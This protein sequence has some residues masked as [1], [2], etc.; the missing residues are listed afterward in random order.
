MGASVADPGVLIV[1]VAV[2]GDDGQVGE[3]AERA[4]QF[5]G[6]ARAWPVNRDFRLSSAQAADVLFEP[7]QERAGV[8][9]T[10]GPG[11]L[12]DGNMLR[13]HDSW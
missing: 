6:V 9:V 8:F 10:A 3:A 11:Q 5:S 7:G 12:D 1:A 4:G 13:H 2:G